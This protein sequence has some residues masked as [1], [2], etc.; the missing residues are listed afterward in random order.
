MACKTISLGN[1]LLWIYS[2]LGI[3]RC[4]WFGQ[5]LGFYFCRRISRCRR[6]G[7]SVEEGSLERS[8][9]RIGFSLVGKLGEQE[10]ITKTVGM[11]F[12]PEKH[13][14]ASHFRIGMDDYFVSKAQVRYDGAAEFRPIAVGVRVDGREHFNV[15]NG[16]LREGVERICLRVTKTSL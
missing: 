10:L 11:I 4:I 16:S 6:L 1:L 14:K 15:E 7:A 9:E 3:D 5:F 13:Q 2:W 8:S 12:A